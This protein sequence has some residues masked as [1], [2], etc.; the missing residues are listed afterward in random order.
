[1]FLFLTLSQS[2]EVPELHCQLNGFAGVVTLPETTAMWVGSGREGTN[3]IIYFKIQLPQG[4][5][6]RTCTSIY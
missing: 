6:N 1:M 4:P 5:G 3:V 2:V